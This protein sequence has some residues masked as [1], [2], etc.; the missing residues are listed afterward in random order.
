MNDE[1]LEEGGSQSRPPVLALL[2]RHTRSQQ[3]LAAQLWTGSIGAGSQGELT[4]YLCHAAQCS[5]G[6]TDLLP[7]I[8]SCSRMA[9]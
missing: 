8:Q 7:P 4:L 6:S 9:L 5:A 2:E 1:I 3:S